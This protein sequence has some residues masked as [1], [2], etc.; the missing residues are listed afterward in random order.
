MEKILQ[1][2]ELTNQRASVVE[3]AEEEEGYFLT[4]SYIELKK[5]LGITTTIT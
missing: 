1:Q 4:I 3:A 5:R 2:L